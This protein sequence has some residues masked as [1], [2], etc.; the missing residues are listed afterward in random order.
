MIGQRCTA[1]DSENRWRPATIV[2]TTEVEFGGETFVMYRAKFRMG[3]SRWVR[4]AEIRAE[5]AA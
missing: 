5:V 2:D 1:K 3:G 4:P